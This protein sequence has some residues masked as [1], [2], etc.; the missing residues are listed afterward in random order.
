MLVRFPSENSILNAL[1]ND[2][3]LNKMYKPD[4]YFGQKSVPQTLAKELANKELEHPVGTNLAKELA[5][6]NS[7]MKNQVPVVQDMAKS[8]YSQALDKIAKPV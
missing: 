1:N 6:H 7:D 8:V 4:G 3:A 2:K 5:F